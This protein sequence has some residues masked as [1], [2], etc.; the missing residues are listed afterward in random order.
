MLFVARAHHV[1]LELQDVQYEMGLIDTNITTIT[2]EQASFGWRLYRT[3][4]I[5]TV[6]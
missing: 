1:R 4:P 6:L 3:A 2:A 5:Q